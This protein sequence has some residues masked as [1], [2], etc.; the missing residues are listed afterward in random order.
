MIPMQEV[1]GSIPGPDS[2]VFFNYGAPLMQT[3]G[4]FMKFSKFGID[5]RWL[6]N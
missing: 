4:N 5:A 2:E 3:E 1:W 6:C